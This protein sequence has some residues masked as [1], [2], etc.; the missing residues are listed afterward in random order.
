MQY[1]CGMR[2][3]GQKHPNN[4]IPKS[5]THPKTGKHLHLSLLLSVSTMI[6]TPYTGSGAKYCWYDGPATSGAAISAPSRCSDCI[7]G[8]G[9]V[10]SSSHGGSGG[11]EGC[12][13]AEEQLQVQQWHGGGG[14]WQG[15]WVFFGFLFLDQNLSFFLVAFSIVWIL[16]CGVSGRKEGGGGRLV[17]GCGFLWEKGE[18]ID[19]F[20]SFKS[21]DRC[22]L[23][24]S[25]FQ[26]FVLSPKR[27][28]PFIQTFKI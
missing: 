16:F 10:R 15:L 21:S 22:F 19:C 18:F 1:G 27:S 25:T 2:K 23:L 9:K 14:K 24:L 26:T 5:P 8:G 12:W 11:A 6:G 17:F 28:A 13:V 7:E 20:A 3:Q 4:F